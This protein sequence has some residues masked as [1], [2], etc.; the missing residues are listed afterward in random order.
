MKIYQPMLAHVQETPFSSKDWIFEIKWNG[1]RTI[2]YTYP[3]LSLQN[4]K[5]EDLASTFPEFLELTTQ[6]L[7]VVLD[8]EIVIMQHGKVDFETL[9]KRTQLTLAKEIKKMARRFPATYIAFDILERDDKSL[10][11]EPLIQRK[12]L[13]Q[14]ILKNTKYVTPSIFADEKGEAYFEAALKE[15][16]DGIVAKKKDSKYKPGVTSSNW[17]EV[18][19]PLILQEYAE[20]RDFTKTSEPLGNDIINKDYIFVVQEH[21]ARNL[22]YDFRL[23][24]E[25]V[26]KSWAVPKG[27]PEKSRIRRLAVETEDHPLEYSEFEGTI[28]QGEYGAGTVKIW[29]KG[30]YELKIWKEDK[31]EFFLRGERLNGMYVLIKLKKLSQKPSSHKEWL[32]IKMKN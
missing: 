31:I 26:L 20:K 23:S 8:G 1:I 3:E 28:P 30:S 7:N 29:D 9:H 12:T 32:L 21:H 4:A 17:I 2:A 18:R 6:G 5:Q 14:K 22:H 19:R 15:G 27:I 13:L 11:E 10:I 16:F 24:R 25:G